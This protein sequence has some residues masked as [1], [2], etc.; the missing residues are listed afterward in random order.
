MYRKIEGEIAMLE[1]LGLTVAFG[2][3][4]VLEDLSFSLG[5]GEV[6]G[7]VAPNGSGKTTL[8]KAICGLQ[9]AKGS[10]AINGITIKKER[11]RF[12]RELFFIEN[13]T[14][15]YQDLTVADHLKMV[16]QNWPSDLSVAKVSQLFKL[17]R[18]G[19]KPVRNMSLGMKQQLLLTMYLL[20]DAQI[21]LFDEPLNGLDPTNTYRFNQLVAHLQE[22][23]KTVIMSSHNL[24]NLS[25]TCTKVMFLAEGVIKETAAP[26]ADLDAVY[27]AL[28]LPA[29]EE[30]LS[31][32]LK[33]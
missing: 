4:R 12:L 3:Q 15:L 2:K 14:H 8:L 9:P 28:F 7:L 29:T 30:V 19:N 21:M 31:W 18:F 16:K 25:D 6:V 5:A 10:V 23:G 26:D 17:E 33:E 20:S 11:T 13:I 32:D 24:A 1:V 27:K 22:S